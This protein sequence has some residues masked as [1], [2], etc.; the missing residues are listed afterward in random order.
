[1]APFSVVYGSILRLRALAYARGIF[2]SHRLPVPVVSVGNL[3]VGGTGK[4]PTVALLAACCQARGKRVGII[5]RGY[6][7][8]S[9]GRQRVVS[10]GSTV[11]LT[12]AEAG[13]EPYLLA[14]SLTGAVVIIG[15]DRYRAGL[16]AVEQFG[17]EVVILDD[18]FQHLRLQRDLNILLLDAQRP[19]GNGMTLPAGLLREPVSAAERADLV[20][21]TRSSAETAVPL[22]GK[23]SCRATHRLVGMKSLTDG[24]VE[25]FAKLAGKRGVAFAGIAD[26]PSFFA[27]LG[28][29]GLD[30]AAALPL[31]DHCRYGEGDITAICRLRDESGADYLITTAKDAVKLGPYLDRLGPVYVAELELHILDPAPLERA[32]DE[33]FR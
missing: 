19:F 6:G 13:D 30:L 17:V 24:A 16:Q 14:A 22:Q 4:T 10:D 3:T 27:S 18:G 2:R 21:S 15:A 32:L 8:A 9:E 5:S 23:P 1:M 12:A 31:P 28:K 7:G 11:L 29:E 20:I 25:G 33:L 26:P